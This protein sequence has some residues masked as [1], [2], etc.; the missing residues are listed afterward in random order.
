[1]SLASVLELPF[2]ERPLE[3]L[4]HF[5]DGRDQVDRD[6]AGFGFT[7]APLVW[8]GSQQGG[9][10]QPVEDALVIALHASDDAAAQPDDIDLSF[11][12]T[13]ERIDVG[14][15]LFL[16]RWL[17]KLPAASAIV[18][19][20]CNP[21]HAKLHFATS[22]PIWYPTG[23]TESWIDDSAGGRIELLAAGGWARIPA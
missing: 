5:E 15:N 2:V 3:E 23:D 14:L 9:A 10:L 4:L 16:S 1:V 18:L 12:M 8:L 22:T 13:S 6:Y 19:A 20:V 11:E 7:R 17:P 21:H